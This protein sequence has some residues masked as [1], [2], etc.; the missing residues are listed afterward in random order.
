[1]PSKTEMM[2]KKKKKSTAVT[3]AKGAKTSKKVVSVRHL[4]SPLNSLEKKSTAKAETKGAQKKAMIPGSSKTKKMKMK[5]ML[6]KK[7]NDK[8]AAASSTSTTNSKAGKKKLLE[9]SALA[10][11]L[12][13]KKMARM[14]RAPK[15]VVVPDDMEKETGIVLADGGVVVPSASMVNGKLVTTDGASSGKLREYATE[16][17]STQHETLWKYKRSIK[18][19]IKRL[20]LAADEGTVKKQIVRVSPITCSEPGVTWISRGD[21]ISQK[22]WC[23]AYRDAQGRKRNKWFNC[24][25]Y[26]N[27]ADTAEKR[28]E[29]ARGRAM[30]VAVNWLREH[31]KQMAELGMQQQKKS[32]DVRQ[33][34]VLGVRWQHTSWGPA[35]KRNRI[36]WTASISA[37]QFTGRLSNGRAARP[38]TRTFTLNIQEW[39]DEEEREAELE[40]LR[41]KAIAQRQK[42]ERE[43]FA[44][45]EAQF[46][47]FQAKRREKLDASAHMVLQDAGPTSGAAIGKGSNDLLQVVAAS[48]SSSSR[49][50][51][52]TG[53]KFVGMKKMAMKKKTSKVN[54]KGTSSSSSTSKAS[55][56]SSSTSTVARTGVTKTV[57]KKMGTKL[58]P[59]LKKIVAANR[60][61]R[62]RAATKKNKGALG[63]DLEDDL[64]ADD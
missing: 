62:L 57:K 9:K 2:K 22:I 14:K 51:P 36:G 40:R 50:S 29:L 60:Q 5:K 10:K 16:I 24:K 11:N 17:I 30:A 12:A 42:W 7:S 27:L 35:E 23:A 39:P 13:M 4:R 20:A 56:A 32:G 55:K 41:Q 58:E 21:R 37:H 44:Y 15:L 8:K 31:K 33:S 6:V 47:Q 52:S 18:D 54:N 46:P 48:S 28:E 59:K 63:G 3:L 38:V 45:E 64:L 34:G 53:K 43:V 19:P 25:H 49:S 61:M 26:V 1:M